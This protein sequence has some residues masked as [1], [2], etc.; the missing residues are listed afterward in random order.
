VKELI[1]YKGNN[2]SFYKGRKTLI[3]EDINRSGD[4]SK[5]LFVNYDLMIKKKCKALHYKISKEDTAEGRYYRRIII[6]D[7][8]V[9]IKHLH[10]SSMTCVFDLELIIV[11]I[12]EDL[13]EINLNLAGKRNTLMSELINVEKIIRGGENYF[14]MTYKD[15]EKEVEYKDVKREKVVTKKIKKAG[16]IIY[17]RFDSSFCEWDIRMDGIINRFSWA[18]PETIIRFEEEEREEIKDMIEDDYGKLN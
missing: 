5:V 3:I 7:Y 18:L 16:M 12:G 4:K 17:D 2:V 11:G 6:W 9:Y 1:K 8:A 13:I 10:K 14:D 15:I